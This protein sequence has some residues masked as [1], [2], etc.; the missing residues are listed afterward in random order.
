MDFSNDETALVGVGYILD[1]DDELKTEETPTPI[2]L[3]TDE[4][5]VLAPDF[6]QK[7]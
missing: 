4:I 6:D 3:S 7:H 1:E 2:K 5:Y